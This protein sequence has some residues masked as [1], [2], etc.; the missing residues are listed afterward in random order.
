M[1]PEQT[2]HIALFFT[3]GISLQIWDQLGLF[4]REVALYRRLQRCGVTVSFVTYGDNLERKYASR[5]PGI[6]ILSN[7]WRLPINWYCCLLPLL[8]SARLRKVSLIKTNQLHGAVNAMRAARLWRKPCIARCGYLRS[9]LIAR[10][11]GPAAPITRA[12]CKEEEHIFMGA[13]RI[14]VTTQA[15]ADEVATRVPQ[16]QNRIRIIPNYV[17]T[18]LFSP[19]EE[20]QYQYDVMFIGRLE[21]EKNLGALLAAVSSLEIRLAIIGTGS[22]GPKLRERFGDC[23]G[24]VMWLGTVPHSSLPEFLRSAKLFVL[25]SLHEGHP[26][27]LLEAM[28]CGLPVIGAATP[29][30]RDVI[31]HGTTGWLCGTDSDSIRAA[32]VHLLSND[33]LRSRLGTNARRYVETQ[34]SLEHILQQELNLYHELCPETNSCRRER[35]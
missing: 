18:M 13:D 11:Y 35:R 23:N 28:A 8:H 2:L 33:E 15:M 34:C 5:L 26:K 10:D 27:A 20:K 6:N 17:D 19:P 1:K 3:T 16:S 32:I 4:D 25:P 14:V 29:G 9:H 21:A 7:W 30:I 31:H 12:V 24:R 22:L